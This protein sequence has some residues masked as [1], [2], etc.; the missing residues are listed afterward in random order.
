MTLSVV[1]TTD[2]TRPR[3]RGK[4]RGSSLATSAL[5]TWS[6]LVLPTDA[7]CGSVNTAAGRLR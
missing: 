3:R 7:T 6:P 5:T 2:S 4:R 1:P